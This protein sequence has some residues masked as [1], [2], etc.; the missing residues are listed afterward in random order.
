MDITLGATVIQIPVRVILAY[1]LVGRF[2]MS[3][4]A[5]CIA[6]GWLCMTVYEAMQYRHYF[7]K[8]EGSLMNEQQEEPQ[9]TEPRM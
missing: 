7:R 4:I 9:K 2:G 6:V 8:G 3:V 5:Y 1:L